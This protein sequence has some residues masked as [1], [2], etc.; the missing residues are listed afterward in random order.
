MFAHRAQAF[1]T[2]TK[3]PLV[4]ATCWPLL[5]A[6]MRLYRASMVA[7]DARGRVYVAHRGK[8]PLFCLDP[9][10]TLRRVIGA[11]SMKE[12]VA[13]NLSGPVPVP[14]EKLHYLH[15]LHI[16]PWNN[17]WI[18]DAGRHLVMRFSP[19]GA[20]T[21]ALG[22]DGVSGC[23]DAHFHQP[24]HVWTAASGEIFVSDGY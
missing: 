22:T 21:F 11:G 18:T 19:E 15:G 6:E 5:P 7:A 3:T 24:T 10:G 13:E 4:R 20:L 1:R 2:T 12:S 23:D 16:D 17:V 14:M 9:D 8:C